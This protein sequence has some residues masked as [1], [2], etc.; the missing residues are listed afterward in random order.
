MAV[1]TVLL[2]FVTLTLN[3]ALVA[4]SYREAFRYLEDMASRDGMPM[5]V[6]PYKPAF[7]YQKNGPWD[8][9]NDNDFRERNELHR[10]DLREKP[11]QMPF[12]PNL[13]FRSVMSIKVDKNISDFEMVFGRHDDYS[14]EETLELCKDLINQLSRRGAY[15]GYFYIVKNQDDGSY[16]IC[17]VNRF[18]ELN[19]FHRMHMFSLA[20]VLVTIFLAFIPI[21]FFS[22]ILIIPIENSFERQKQFISDSSHE[23]RTPISVIDA[24]L[25]VVMSEYPDNKWLNYIKDENQRMG[26]LVKDLL[27]LTR[28]DQHRTKLEKK[29]LDLSS[30]INNAVLPFESVI[31]EEGKILELFIKPDLKTFGDEN[32]IKQIITILVDNAIKYSDENGLIRVIAYCENSYNYIKVYNTGSGIKIENL[33]NVFHRFFRED[34]ARTGL[35]GGYGL[36]LS[37]AKSLTEMHYGTLSA[38][39]DGESWVEF[40]LKLR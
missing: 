35:K 11:S 23:L 33:E 15:R 28:N 8:D 9:K 20:A 34:K 12:A 37:I 31:Y 40:T 32:S 24:N 5:A 7:S 30:V 1:I 21:F 19:F 16:L 2:T 39:S 6:P 4:R 10:H 25:S 29:E 22:K 17:L 14:K 3:L 36:G 26:Q 18:A 13:E 38:D 27:L